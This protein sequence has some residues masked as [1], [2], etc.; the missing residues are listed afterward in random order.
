MR[1]AIHALFPVLIAVVISAPPSATAQNGDSP[2]IAARKAALNSR[3]TKQFDFDERKLGNF[4]SMPMNWR[5]LVEPGYPRF[6][7]PRFDDAIGHDAA[8]SFH[9]RLTNG[10]LGAYYLAR[11]IPVDP[12]SAYRIIA[13]VRPR[14]LK[15]GAAF[16]T[17]GYLGQNLKL[18]RQTERR[19]ELVRGEGDDEPWTR[20]VIDLPGG[21]KNARCITLSCRMEQNVRE[22]AGAETSAAEL[23]YHD[24]DGEA[25]F[26]DI[27]VIRMP[28]ITLAA[29]DPHGIFDAGRRPTFRISLRDLN[30]EA[31]KLQMELQNADGRAIETRKINP[32]AAFCWP[33]AYDP[34][35]L[36][37]GCYLA[38]LTV[39]AGGIAEETLARRFV[40]LAGEK[41]DRQARSKSFGVILNDAA[42]RA[43]AALDRMTGLLG[44]GIAKINIWRGDMDDA[45]VVDG[46]T[47]H[48]QAASILVN[49]EIDLVGV[50]AAPPAGLASQYPPGAQTLTDVLSSD[51]AEWRPYFAL[52]LTRFNARMQYWQLGADTGI[53]PDDLSLTKKSIEQVEAELRSLSAGTPLAIPLS[54]RLDPALHPAGG[55]IKAFIQSESDTA[56]QFVNQLRPDA[57]PDGVRWATIR[58]LSADR[59]E[60]RGR[61][62]DFAQAII[63]SRSRGVDV[64][65][66]DAPWTVRTEVD[67]SIVEPTEEFILL[68]TLAHELAGFER[69]ES[70]Y[71][72]PGVQA[73]LFTSADDSNGVL[74]VWTDG[75][76][77]RAANIML[78][79]GTD[80]AQIDL[81]G[82][83][84]TVERRPDGIEAAV[85]AMPTLITPVNP[86]LV[87][88]SSSFALDEPVLAPTVE[89]HHRILSFVNTTEARIAGR[90]KLTAP[91]GWMVA[92]R[93][94]AIDVN[95]GETIQVPVR[96]R[97]PANQS[98]GEFELLGRIQT[99]GDTAAS[100]TLRAQAI[101]DMPGL[102]ME[103]ISYR[104]ADRMQVVQRIT[105]RTARPLNLRASLTSL[106]MPRQ[107]RAINDLL[108]GQSVI[109]RFEL[110][111]PDE[112][113]GKSVR[114]SVEQVGGP[115][116][117]NK[118]I[119]FE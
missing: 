70:V 21:I 52:V 31:L 67:R 56:L 32:H 72:A 22:D 53:I 71:V 37:P 20:V 50:I 105:N 58:P 3:I 25:W 10:N 60:R 79:F 92:P 114:V 97:L 101:V 7:E 91:S 111:N 78:D 116:R 119:Q 1:R 5:Q 43:P 109:R 57:A 55:R 68:R 113:A 11:D 35:P 49:Q 59:Y 54:M 85:G 19:S 102:D 88:L 64:V 87:R 99:P 48:E 96:I 100:L 80:A 16:L 84:R 74:A 90:L 40:V 107:W 13:W 95:P 89:R 44:A 18:M 46:G 62:V 28:R 106:G 45:A 110:A 34:P 103:V 93:I 86:K 82:R 41:P 104:E 118:L 26:D 27:A 47:A 24:V 117:H 14:R 42:V 12:G 76:A 8:P 83:R 17:C 23:T 75:R 9:F 98:A 51:P 77:E 112:L 94:A 36:E 66:T 65:F 33:V 39:N 15:H 6:L 115:L 2:I 61:L 63:E 4:E 73:R 81:W 38:K 29:G 108:P 30:C 69:V